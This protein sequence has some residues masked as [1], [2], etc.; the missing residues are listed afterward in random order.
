MQFLPRVSDVEL[1]SLF[2]GTT[3]VMVNSLDKE[4]RLR[5]FEPFGFVAPVTMSD[6]DP[7]RTIAGDAALLV[8]SLLSMPRLKHLFHHFG[9]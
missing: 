3:C 5:I 8:T 9:A 1:A 6:F 7:I 2:A 4:L